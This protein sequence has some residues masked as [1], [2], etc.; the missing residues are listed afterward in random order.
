MARSIEIPAFDGS[1][2]FSAYLA[3]PSQKPKAA[4]VLIQEIFGLNPG[5]LKMCDDWAAEGYLAIAP[6]LF[7]RMEPG[8]TAD[9]DNAQ[10]LPKAMDYYTRLDKDKAIADIE[11]AIRKGR[12]MAGGKV[13]TVGYCLGGLMAFL[14]ATRTDSDAIVS[15]YGGGTEQFVSE[16]HAI[17]K[18]TILHLAKEDG[19]IGPD[20]QATIH[21]ALDGNR[22]VTIYDY[23][24]VDHAFARAY[25]S[26]RREEAANLAD[27]RTREF[28]ARH[29][30]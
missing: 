20:A 8:F 26:S 6:D 30:G 1:G 7:W 9:P 25:G 5:I 4:I 3:E 10:E 11:A 21:G 15:Y 22:H 27:G 12:E 14:T 16:S 23:E 19:Y 28:F 17:G 29:L 13:G 2:R 18:P 24:D